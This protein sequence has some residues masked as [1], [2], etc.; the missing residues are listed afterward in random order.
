MTKLASALLLSTLVKEFLPR[1]DCL[2]NDVDLRHKSCILQF[3]V[4]NINIL[5]M[6]LVQCILCKNQMNQNDGYDS[7]Y[8]HQWNISWWMGLSAWRHL[9]MEVF[10]RCWTISQSLKLFLFSFIKDHIAGFY[11][12]NNLMCQ[13]DFPFDWNWDANSIS[14][15]IPWHKI[16]QSFQSPAD[17]VFWC[18]ILILADDWAVLANMSVNLHSYC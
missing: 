16:L 8:L 6:L 7:I 11:V 15:K 14:C 3:I 4:W 17:E 9:L 12:G 2:F 18:L 5:V 10:W 13:K 1:F